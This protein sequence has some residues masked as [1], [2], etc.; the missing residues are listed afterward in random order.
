MNPLSRVDQSP[1]PW[2]IELLTHGISNLLPM[3]YRTLSY[4]IMNPLPIVYRTP[5]PWYFDPSTHSISPRSFGR[6]DGVQNTMTT[7]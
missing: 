5:Y 6:N 4:C 2:Y 3:V 7:I 1:A